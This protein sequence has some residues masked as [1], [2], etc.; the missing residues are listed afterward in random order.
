MPYYKKRKEWFRM[1]K[2][3]V[4]LSFF[5][6]FSRSDIVQLSPIVTKQSYSFHGWNLP[7]IYGMQ[8]RLTPS[9]REGKE[10]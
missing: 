8:L 6:I 2:Q 3:V 9:N 1:N 10:G 4:A 7:F 5:N